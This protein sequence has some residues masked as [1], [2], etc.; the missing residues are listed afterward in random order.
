[1]S[2][3]GIKPTDN[4]LLARMAPDDLESI[5]PHLELVHLAHSQI[6]IEPHEPIRQMYFPVTALGSLV[7]VL[8]DGSTVEAGMVGRE[9]VVGVP[10]LL[11]TDSTP[12]QT[13]AQ[14]AGEAFRIRAEIVKQRYDKGGSV[15]QILNRYIHILFVVA[16]QSSACN[17]KH[18]VEARLARWLL[19]SSDGIASDDV[20]L[21]QEYLAVMLGV[22]R[23]GVTEAAVKLQSAGLIQYTR[24]HVRII[25]R[26]GLAATACECYAFVTA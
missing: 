9:G 20:G 11:D 22:R 10:V 6:L 21:T 3:A 12:M 7:A 5:A 18:V 4:N 19:M 23:P 25:D 26:K 15:F 24:G 1:M 2:A 14:I 16:S 8:A 17:R 13:V